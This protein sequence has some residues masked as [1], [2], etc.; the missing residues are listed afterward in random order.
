MRVVVCSGNDDDDEVQ[1]VMRF[2][3]FTAGRL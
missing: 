1:L 2:Q 3:S